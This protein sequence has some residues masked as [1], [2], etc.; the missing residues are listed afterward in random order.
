MLTSI[1]NRGRNLRAAGEKDVVWYWAWMVCIAIVRFVVPVPI[2]LR[3]VFNIARI[4]RQHDWSEATQRMP[5]S[6]TVASPR[7]TDEENPN[8][9]SPPTVIRARD[10]PTES[11]NSNSATPQG[12]ERVHVHSGN[13]TDKGGLPTWR[14]RVLR[15]R[16]DSTHSAS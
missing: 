4:V 8:L 14:C 10:A 1:I 15:S 12:S 3:S 13:H 5:P 16:G 6:S 11:V 2:A 7:T 9:R